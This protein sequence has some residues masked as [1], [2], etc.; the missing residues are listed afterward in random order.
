MTVLQSKVRGRFRKILWPSQSIW[1]LNRQILGAHIKIVFKIWNFC[2]QFLSN[3]AIT[4]A[5]FIFDSVVVHLLTWSCSKTNNEKVSGKHFLITI[6][7]FY[8]VLKENKTFFVI[9]FWTRSI[10]CTTTESNIK[11]AIVIAQFSDQNLQTKIPYV[12]WQIF[13]CAPRFCLFKAMHYY[14]YW[15]SLATVKY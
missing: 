12:S 7:K 14:S 6:E 8:L 15:A 1:T 10:R 5:N 4:M 11:L 13:I 3:W 9:C 2:L